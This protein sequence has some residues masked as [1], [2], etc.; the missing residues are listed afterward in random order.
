MA[1]FSLWKAIGKAAVDEFFFDRSCQYKADLS[2]FDM[3][4]RD[5]TYEASG[6]SYL[7]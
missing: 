6:Y 5:V 2:G 7:F 1:H 4:S 3:W